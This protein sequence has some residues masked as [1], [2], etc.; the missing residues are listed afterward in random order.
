MFHAYVTVFVKVDI[1]MKN[2]RNASKIILI[3]HAI[4]EEN[5]VNK[6]CQMFVKVGIVI[7]EINVSQ[8]Y[9]II[10]HVLKNL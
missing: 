2:L 9:A 10:I 1:V 6:N 8:K 3:E 7:V 5:I 4:L